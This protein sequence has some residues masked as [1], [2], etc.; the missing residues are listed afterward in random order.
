MQVKALT[1]V[2]L[3]STAGFS[4]NLVAVELEGFIKHQ[5]IYQQELTDTDHHALL[6]RFLIRHS[7]QTSSNSS[8]L[9]EGISAY[10][11]NYDNQTFSVERNTADI[12]Q[13]I[14]KTAVANTSVSLGRHV[15]S[16][17]N[18]RQ[19]GKRE[20]TNVRRRFDG[21]LL[22]QQFSSDTTVSFYHGYSVKSKAKALDDSRDQDLTASGIIFRK[23]KLL[24][25]AI[26][27]RDSRGQSQDDIYAIETEYQHKVEAFDAFYQL[28]YQFGDRG[29]QQL[30]AWFSL[31]EWAYTLAQHRLSLTASYASGGSAQDADSH[32]FQPLFAKAPYYSEAG[33]FATTNIQHIGLSWLY[34]LTENFSMGLDAKKLYK[35]K[36]NGAIYG[37]GQSLLLPADQPS[38][39]ALANNYSF[40]SEYKFSPHISLELVASFIDIQN[41]SNQSPALRNSSFFETMLHY[42]F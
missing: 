24:V 4:L 14:F 35:V 1:S 41:G 27:Y 7:W 23:Q 29:P 28:I 8:L 16:I 40:K 30:S 20:G 25:H 32:E 42:R 13:L 19:L 5:D 9:L 26:N 33:V 11:S 22:D 36:Q 17:G 31:L 39:K 6:S 38:G 2:A 21:V 10:D 3:L 18:Q 12:H 34:P 37:P 15:W